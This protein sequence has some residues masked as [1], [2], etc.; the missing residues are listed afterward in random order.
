MEDNGFIYDDDMHGVSTTNQQQHQHKVN[1][2]GGDNK[3]TYEDDM[4]DMST[5][6]Q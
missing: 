5:A 6:N 4:Q 2:Q 3:V 1:F